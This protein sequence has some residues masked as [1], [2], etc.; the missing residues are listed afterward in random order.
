MKTIDLHIHTTASDGTFT[1]TELIDYAIKKK[2][3]AI[4][5]TDHDTMAGI[6][7]AQS[8]IRNNNL[9]LELI[10]GMEVSTSFSASP[11]GL[12]ILAYFIDK[13]EEEL[14]NILKSVRNEI[15]RNS[16]SSP[17]AIKIINEHGGLASLAHPKD[18]FLNLNELDDLLGQLARV[19]LKGIE[20]IYPTHSA[21]ETKS[22]K[23]IA[24][25]HELLITGGT[26]FHG[27]RKPSIDLGSGFG[28]LV[29][30]YDIVDSLKAA[31][32]IK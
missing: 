18:Y 7:E 1:P 19:G 8:Y 9:A 16:L 4:A 11:Y 17:D 10:P 15:Q 29:I 28:D 23:K 24:S 20:C 6:Q 21:A 13:N 30:P 27:T 5:I 22:F 25:Q 14:K 26:D 31:I 32:N 3:S 12:H 2:L